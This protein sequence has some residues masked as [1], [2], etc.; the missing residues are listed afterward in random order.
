MNLAN[1]HPLL[2]H[3]PIGIIF[4]GFLLELWQLKYPKKLG[5]EVML[6]ILGN[7]AIFALLSVATGWFLG[8]GGDYDEVMLD[9]HKWLG[10][11][12][13]VTAIGLFLI[14]T[15]E[16]A[17]AKKGYLPLFAV[18]LVLLT[19]TGHFGGNMTHG[20]DFLFA[21]S[22][23]ETVEIENIEEAQ[24]FAEVINPILNRKC[25]SCHNPSKIKGGLQL[26]TQAAI[27]AGG[28]TG[29]LFDSVAEFNSNL[30]MHRT[31]LSLEDEEHMPPKG[32]MQL[33]EEEKLLLHWWVENENCFDCKVSDLEAD[34]RTE[35]VLASLETDNSTRGVLARELDFVSSE[36]LST[37]RQNHISIQQL[38]EDNPLLE[39]NFS[40]RKDITEEDFEA[41][42]AVDDNIVE[43]NLGNTNLDDKLS[44]HLKKFKNLT[45]LQLNHT[46]IT[47]KS[48]KPLQ[49]L[50]FLESLSLFG[51]QF[52]EDNLAVLDDLPVLKDIYLSPNGISSDRIAELQGNGIKVHGQDI[53]E[54]FKASKLEPP[55]IIAE[56][57]IFNDSIL[58]SLSSVF[59]DA[60]TIYRYETQHGDTITKEYKEPFFL[61]KSTTLLAY[62][63]K[64]GW[65]KS[66]YAKAIFL[67]TGARISKATFAAKPHEKYK[68][69]GAKT[70]IDKKRGSTNFV[71]G[72]WIGYEASN[73]QSTLVM[74]KPTKISTVSVGHLSAPTSWIFSPIGYKIWG[75]KEGSGYK[76]LKTVK[77]PP[78]PP[79]NTVERQLI[80]IDIEETELKSVRVQVLNQMKNPDWHQVPGGN[81]FIFID[82]IVLN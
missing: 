23:S 48:L 57:E 16:S 12:F 65:G 33:T 73:L 15:R 4:I 9:R 41:L 75:A 46:K 64:E 19:L 53:E 1:L 8:D 20:E 72:Q 27:L 40:R 67:R 45:K 44:K 5:K 34:A 76:L 7:A 35:S 28:D 59:D 24:V 54:K 68:A 70:L 14:K 13:T 6:F 43:I 58:V 32:K 17:W 56:N 80:N 39:V 18:S 74:E 71:D 66:D 36:E 38:A 82:E 21:D 37:I 2:V 47:S 11:A 51:L 30:L 63:E 79:S 31:H 26:H 42:K 61:K 55:V 22:K 77:M 10:I 81:S 78:N 29:S 52:K 25:V 60:R 49:K 69:Q 3:L 62:S 50:E